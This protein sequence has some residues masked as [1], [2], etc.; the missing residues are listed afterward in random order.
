MTP[1]ARQLVVQLVMIFRKGGKLH[2]H[3]PIHIT[4][5]IVIFFK[6]FHFLH[7]SAHR[8]NTIIIETKH[9]YYRITHHCLQNSAKVVLVSFAFLKN[10]HN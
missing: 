5:C 6:H 3:A 4:T 9:N 10:N 2:S 1:H 8:R 7:F